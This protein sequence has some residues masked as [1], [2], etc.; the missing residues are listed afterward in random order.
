MTVVSVAANHLGPDA[1]L[2]EGQRE[3]H[4]ARASTRRTLTLALVVLAGGL[5]WAWLPLGTTPLG[6]LPPPS[7]ART[8][9][10]PTPLA[11]DG[12]QISIAPAQS[13]SQ[14]VVPDTVRAVP[15][16]R[17][18]GIAH[19]GPAQALAAIVYDA[20]SDKIRT[21]AAGESVAGWLVVSVASTGVLLRRDGQEHTLEMERPAPVSGGGAPTP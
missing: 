1:L 8:T 4:R 7:V 2:D 17:L 21:C 9:G 19:Q 6:A 14:P 5:V 10:A 15:E 18:V 20:T 13:E 3:L 16:V 11:L 12:F